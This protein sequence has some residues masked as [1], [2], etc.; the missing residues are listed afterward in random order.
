[1]VQFALPLTVRGFAQR[2]FQG[3]NVSKETRTSKQLYDFLKLQ[4]PRCAKS[5]LAAG[6]LSARLCKPLSICGFRA[7]VDF[8]FYLSVSVCSLRF[9]FFFEGLVNF[10]KTIFPAVA[11]QAL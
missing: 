7:I 4:T 3:S 11:L 5:L 2:G 9:L 8:I 10:L 6:V 1:L